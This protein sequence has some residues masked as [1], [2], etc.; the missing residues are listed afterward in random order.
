[1]A[2][3]VAA[4]PAAA[5]LPEQPLPRRRKR[6]PFS[7]RGRRIWLL[8]Q[9]E[10][11]PQ[12]AAFSVTLL[13]FGSV[14]A[15]LTEADFE[16]A[17]IRSF[18][19]AL[20][21]SIVTMT[22]V[23]YGDLTP[24]SPAGKMVGVMLM[25]GGM[26]LLSLFTATIASNL[27]ARR[28]RE[29]HDLS[30]IRWR[31]HVLVCGWNQYGER[32]LDG[33]VAASGRKTEIILVNAEPED[34]T[35][36]LVARYPNAALHY[37]HGDPA[38]EGTLERA[39]VRFARSAVVLA[40]MSR[41][42]AAAADERTT[43][44]TLAIKSLKPDIKVT[45]EALDLGSEAHLRRAGAD[46]IVISGEFNGFMLSSA[47]VSPGMSQVIRRLLSFGEG[48]L[49]RQPIPP[50]YVGKTFGEVF[51]VLRQQSGFLT[52]AIVTEEPALTLDDLL[53]DDYSL[54][55]EFIRQQFIQAGTEYL[56]FEEGETH[57]VVNPPD[58]YVVRLHDAAIGIP[59][60][61]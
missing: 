20:W 57:V 2:G 39:H 42:P 5:E 15:Y 6:L 25:L 19:D 35:Q 55:D 31:N 1:M 26:G 37:V 44:I 56:R 21:Y 51:Q 33:L 18:G 50:E 41:S 22:T 9:R 34:T 59:R 7:A 12:L 29:E 24:K 16:D 49:R 17:S 52:L 11:I 61:T 53:T 43:L 60:N 46:D 38:A 28:I 23:G 13:V 4:S 3:P 47:A 36:D 58:S 48:E 8:A 45:A 32:V 40:D 27:V 14:A 30:D 54:I 10:N